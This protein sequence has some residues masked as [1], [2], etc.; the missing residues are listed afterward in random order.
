MSKIGLFYGST[1]GNTESVAG[2]IKDAFDELEADVVTV[3]NVAEASIED[4]KGFDYLILGTPTWY[5]GELQDDWDEFLPNLDDLD[6]SAKKVA[7]F[8]LGDQ[9]DYPDTFVD[10]LGIL[11]NKVKERGSQLAGS[12]PLEGY[13]FD[14]STAVQDGRFMGLIIDEDNQDDLTGERVK[15]WV[16]QIKGEFGL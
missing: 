2:Q 11:A 7:L 4:M 5:D 9:E 16:N 1:T 8:G 14:A 6:L 13:E 10:G 15:T 12:W 3:F